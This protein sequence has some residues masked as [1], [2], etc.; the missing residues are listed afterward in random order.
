[1]M[2]PS[3]EAISSMIWN[4][5]NT[6]IALLALGIAIWGV[7]YGRKQFRLSQRQDEDAK[8]QTKVDE[9]WSQKFSLVA[10]VLTSTS[11]KMIAV[12]QQGYAYY[13]LF[14]NIELRQRIEA[15]LINLNQTNMAIHVRSLTF[16]QL[17]HQDI[18]RTIADVLS[19][20]EKARQDNPK[21]LKVLDI[22]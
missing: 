19:A 9:E 10:R 8:K 7:G 15:L 14:P 11:S 13:L 21:M 16:D 20:V 17:R 22:W 1:M 18:R 12:P 5:I 3:N 2:N 4:L 6:F